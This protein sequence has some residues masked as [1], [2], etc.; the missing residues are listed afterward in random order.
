M[1][2]PGMETAFEE[3]QCNAFKP[4]KT[5]DETKMCKIYSKD[6]YQKCIKGYFVKPTYIVSLNKYYGFNFYEMYGEKFLNCTIKLLR[7]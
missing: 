2:R 3:R 1:Q 7:M 4:A 6:I 5:T